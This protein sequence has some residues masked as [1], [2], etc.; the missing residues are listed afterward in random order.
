MSKAIFIMDMPASCEECMFHWNTY[1]ENDDYV[2]KCEALNNKTIDGY[3]RKYDGCPLK[4]MIEKQI[5]DYPEYTSYIAGFNDGWDA[6]IYEILG[7]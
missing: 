4:E 5:R 7:E 1:D 2:D 6:C 3:T